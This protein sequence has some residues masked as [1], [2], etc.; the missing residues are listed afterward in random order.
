MNCS[1]GEADNFCSPP[2]VGAAP[3][4]RGNLMRRFFPRVEIPICVSYREDTDFDSRPTELLD[5]LHA[6]KL[7]ASDERELARR[8]FHS[9]PRSPTKLLRSFSRYARWAIRTVTPLSRQSG[10]QFRCPAFGARSCGE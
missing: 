1:F 3:P 6:C 8:H 5:F 2:A 9:R 4:V 7:Y 10:Q